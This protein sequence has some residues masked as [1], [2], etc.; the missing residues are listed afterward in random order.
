[1]E[2]EVTV[3]PRTLT[4]TRL[5]LH[6]HSL[7]ME[8]SGNELQ[9]LLGLQVA[10]FEGGSWQERVKGERQRRDIGVD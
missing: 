2:V 4:R 3:K 5:I 6:P 8:V 7:H 10:G 1:M 9:L